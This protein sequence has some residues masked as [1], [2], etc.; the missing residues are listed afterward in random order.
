MSEQV[1]MC[2][3]KDGER[4]EGVGELWGMERGERCERVSVDVRV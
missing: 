4:G 1:R 3:G 2:G